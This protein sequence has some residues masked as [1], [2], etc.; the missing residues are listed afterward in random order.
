M[1]RFYLY[2]ENVV[3]NLIMLKEKK[4]KM[5][6][7]VKM[8]WKHAH[9]NSFV[10]RNELQVPWFCGKQLFLIFFIFD[11]IIVGQPKRH[12]I[13]SGWSTFVSSKRLVAGDSFIFLRSSLSLPHSLPLSLVLCVLKDLTFTAWSMLNY[14][15]ITCVFMY[16]LNIVFSD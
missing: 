10:V 8:K 6:F 1:K 3:L 14:H 4:R 16:L 13:T 5:Y 2:L 12:L 7:I 15:C 11:W 9:S